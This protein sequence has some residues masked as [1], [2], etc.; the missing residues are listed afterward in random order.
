MGAANG[1]VVNKIGTYKLAVVAKENGVPFY[2]VV[3]TPTIDLATP[4]GEEVPIEERDPEEVT[5]I[6]GQSIV[7]LGVRAANPAFDITPHRYVTGIITEEG[8]ITPP[9]E[10]GLRRAVEGSPFRG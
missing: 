6:F 7:P 10:D 3:P 2:A 8:I 9:F 1:D 5:H 4:S